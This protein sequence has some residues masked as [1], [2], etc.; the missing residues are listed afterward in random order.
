M[1]VG[2][3]FA[4]FAYA[5]I[6]G[7]ITNSF[8]WVYES[9]QSLFWIVPL[10]L[11]INFFAGFLF[12]RSHSKRLRVCYHGALLLCAFYLST[13]FSTGMQIYLAFR[14]IPAETTLY[15]WNL[16]FCFGVHFLIFWNSIL[17]IY[18]TS[19]QL[20]IKHRIIGALCGWIPGINLLV[21]IF[22]SKIVVEECMFETKK[23]TV[24][25][26]R[27]EQKIC[28][29]KYPLLLVHGF[30]FRDYKYINYW[31]RIPKELEYNGATIF[32]GN[33]ESA[34]IVP[35]SARQIA[36]RIEQ[37]LQETGAEKVNIIAHSKGGL[38]CR[39][40]LSELGMAHKV[41]SLTTINTPHHGCRYATYFLSKTPAFLRNRFAKTYN[42][43]LRKVGEQNVDFLQAAGDLTDTSC[44]ALNEQLHTPEGVFCQSFGS[45]MKY[46][47]SGKFPLNI[48]YM[49]VKRFD[50]A[51]DGLVSEPS[52]HWG[53]RYTLLRATGLRGISHGDV[54]DLN[55]QNIKGFDVR[56][57]YV[58]LVK[59]LKDRGL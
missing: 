29:T 54:V 33:H 36:D 2:F 28:A 47:C 31:G 58:Q 3:V 45:V 38:D 55:R 59:D 30:F 41:A 11:F 43:A 35:I 34:A 4:T 26:A 46:A 8:L 15:L 12:I 48:S 18:L 10:F 53:E 19:I 14:L 23:E 32:Y 42:T 44:K 21:L 37:V 9:P 17:C 56:E 50:G 51:N 5:G 25:K 57:F 1:S 27:K 20:G 24:N 16:L 52:F 40:V 39:Y 13:L 7:L 6:I 22:I 49:I